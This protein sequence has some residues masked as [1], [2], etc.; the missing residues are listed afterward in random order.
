MK[1]SRKQSCLL[2][3]ITRP[4]IHLAYNLSHSEYFMIFTL[5]FSYYAIVRD[6]IC[7]YIQQIKLK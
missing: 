2:Y 5:L 7:V 4:Y 1:P 3:V 6:I